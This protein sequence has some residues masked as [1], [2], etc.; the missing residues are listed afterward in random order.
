MRVELGKI[1]Y[2]ENMYMLFFLK[3]L[4][5][6]NFIGV[7]NA[8]FSLPVLLSKVLFDVSN[9]FSVDICVLV[10]RCKYLHGS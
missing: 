10:L 9:S 4:V 7:D 2:A 1:C 8:S 3:R 5:L 6:E